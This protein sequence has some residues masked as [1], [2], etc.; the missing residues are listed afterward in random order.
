LDAVEAT[1]SDA[2]TTTAGCSALTELDAVAS[3]AETAT[4]VAS[5]AALTTPPVTGSVIAGSG[6]HMPLGASMPGAHIGT[7]MSATT[8]VADALNA[9]VI[10]CLSE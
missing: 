2:P 8:V 9:S 6:V 10:C 5:A 3:R 4:A 7:A 1:A